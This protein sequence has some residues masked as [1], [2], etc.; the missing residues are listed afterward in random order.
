MGVHD[1]SAAAL[2]DGSAA[3]VVDGSAES[4]DPPAAPIPAGRLAGIAAWLEPRAL[5]IAAVTAV[6]VLSLAGIYL[7][8]SQD[9]WL[10]LVAGRIVARS[11]IPHHDYLTVMAHGARWVDQ[12]WL[13]QWTMYQ[14]YRLGGL[15]LLSIGYVTLITG[16]FALGIAA[17]R[18]FG[19]GERPLV[20]VLPFATFFYMVSAVSVRT[21]GFAYPL[22][23]LTLWLV[24]SEVRS[25][26]RRRIYLVLPIL[27]LWA[28]VHGSVT[29]GVGIVVIFGLVTLGQAVRAD[30]PSGLRNAKALILTIGAP[31]TLLATPYGTGV[32]HYYTSTL[33]NS[34]FGRLV[35]EWR[36][37]T[38]VMVLGA[39]YLVFLVTVVWLLGRSGRR[40]PTFDHL[41]L[42]MLGLGGILAVRNLTWFGFGSVM[43]LPLTVGQVLR[44]A[45]AAARRR[46][47][48]LTLAT[49]CA[50][51]V[52][53]F[54][55]STVVHPASWFEHTY[56][57][58]AVTR[59][60]AVEQEHPGTRIF[61]DVRFA[62]WLIW[63]DPRLAGLVAYDTSFELLSS[64][65]LETLAALGAPPAAGTPDPLARYGVLVLD[66]QNKSGNRKLLDRS[67][68][69]VILRSKRVLVATKPIR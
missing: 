29:L 43:L 39:P 38:S 7:H 26:T 28:N 30:G 24:A 47:V 57:Q 12:Q 51:L 48:N 41:V 66:P 53:L 25:P 54:T 34:E 55:V 13:A 17:A 52:V 27:V 21:Q 3:A 50:G 11:G 22:F 62:D 45:P 35:T 10:A 67:G 56:D 1:G 31:L 64:K 69:A 6:A 42:I 60:E 8:I 15:A 32:I 59:V 33:L 44:P 49:V 58:R 20:L 5:Y 16:S 37:V 40:T 68:T 61:A 14:L 2:V 36:P 19:A 4:T 23:A 63:H 65:Q 18:R 9:T 46:R